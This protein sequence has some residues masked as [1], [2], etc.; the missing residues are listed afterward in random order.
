MGFGAE[1]VG[2]QGL[3]TADVFAL[4]FALE[5]TVGAEDEGAVVVNFVV[6]G[7]E[8]DAG[9]LELEHP[10]PDMPEGQFV[11][12]V[13]MVA[14]GLDAGLDGVE[15]VAVVFEKFQQEVPGEVLAVDAKGHDLPG[16]TK[17]K[18]PEMNFNRE[19]HF[20]VNFWD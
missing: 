20:Y 19:F 15:P 12:V 5:T 16:V 2:L 1:V 13:W 4:A 7:V 6:E 10:L 17:V 9:P 8:A 3:G 18:C 11:F 14:D